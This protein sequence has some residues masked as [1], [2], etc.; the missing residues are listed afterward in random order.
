MF[1][2]KEFEGIYYSRFIAS[3]MKVKKGA[4]DGDEFRAWLRSL[5]I[6]D[7][8]MTEDEIWDIYNLATNGK[9]ELETDCKIFLINY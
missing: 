3:Y 6:N 8:T 4:F 1:E 2:N 5:S 7:K 9:L